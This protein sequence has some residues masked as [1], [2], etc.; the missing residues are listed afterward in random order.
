MCCKRIQQRYQLNEIFV[1]I[2]EYK[3]IFA[4]FQKAEPLF[5]D[6]WIIFIR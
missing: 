6:F 5:P 1:Y 4:T 2:R 3:N